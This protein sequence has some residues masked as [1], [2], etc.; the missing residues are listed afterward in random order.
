M[1]V[2]CES[3]AMA[4]FRSTPKVDWCLVLSRTKNTAHSFSTFF[5]VRF[6]M[7]FLLEVAL[8]FLAPEW[9]PIEVFG[10]QERVDCQNN[11]ASESAILSNC[12]V[13]P[14]RSCSAAS[15]RQFGPE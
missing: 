10:S 1:S 12:N 14:P 15:C 11:H 9:T 5:S 6:W 7:V 4:I 2:K 8:A 3:I 13:S